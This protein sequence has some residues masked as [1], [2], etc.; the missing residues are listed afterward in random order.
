MLTPGED[1]SRARPS[2]TV[3][4]LAK[5]LGLDVDTSVDRDDVDGAAAKAKAYAGAGNVLIS[6][7][8]GQLAKIAEAL[9]IKKFAKSTGWH[10]DIKYPGD[11]FDL[12]WVAPAPYKEITEVLSEQVPGLDDG[13]VSPAVPS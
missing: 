2:Q 7:E 10:G 3:A 12:I 11:R 6:W 8:H 9:G 5:A 1:G 4:P 13:R